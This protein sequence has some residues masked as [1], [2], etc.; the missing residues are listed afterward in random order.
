[1]SEVV[2]WINL[3]DALRDGRPPPN[4]DYWDALLQGALACRYVA[5][6]NFQIFRARVMPLDRE[7]DADPLAAGELGPPPPGMATPGRLNLNGVSYFYGALD[8]DTAIAE[9]RP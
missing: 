6:A 7:L 9:V 4:S 8:R 5:S 1:M 2:E 3:T